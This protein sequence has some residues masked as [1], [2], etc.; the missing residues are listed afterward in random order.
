MPNGGSDC[1]G[2]CWFNARNKGEAGYRDADDS[3]PNSCTIRG[4]A[5]ENPFWTYC[6]NHPHHRPNRDPIP[7][8]PVFID[9]GGYPYR[10]KQWQP[11]PDT[12][13]VRQHLLDLVRAICEQPAE[14]YPMGMYSDEIIVWQLGEFREAR[15]AHELRRIA[16]FSPEASGGRFGRTRES[17]VAAAKQALGK[18]GED[19]GQPGAAA[20]GAGG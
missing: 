12:E 9:A 7:I 15:A 2:T 1:C 14:E 5:I 8:G 19:G 11:S 16:A 3:E 18:L 17:L 13:A 4:L 6:T 10:R 20:A